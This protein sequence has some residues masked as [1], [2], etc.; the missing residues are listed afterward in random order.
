MSA[1][2]LLDL[3]DDALELVVRAI[4]RLDQDVV[5][6]ALVCTRLQIALRIVLAER[7][8]ALRKEL[9]LL[10]S[11][12][13]GKLRTHVEGIFLSEERIRY[14]RT[15]PNDHM[16][17][18][19]GLFKLRQRQGGCTLL[20]LTA[21]DLAVVRPSEVP[22]GVIWHMVRVAP[23]SVLMNCFVHDPAHGACHSHLAD[24][25][26]HGLGLLENRALLK[27]AAAHGRVDVL[28]ALY[29]W[30][31]HALRSILL[32]K[33][34]LRALLATTPPQ[35]SWKP[36]RQ[37][38]ETLVLPATRHCQKDVLAWINEKALLEMREELRAYMPE[39]RVLLFGVLRLKRGI[40]DWG[41]M[42]GVHHLEFEQQAASM[43]VLAAE[44]G[45]DE[46]FVQALDDI[47]KLWHSEGHLPES[48]WIG[49]ACNWL[50]GHLFGSRIGRGRLIRTVVAWCQEHTSTLR[51]MMN[52]REHQEVFDLMQLQHLNG[53]HDFLMSLDETEG[54]VD[55]YEWL[56]A[57]APEAGRDARTSWC[58]RARAQ[59]WEE[60]N[61][62]NLCDTI[63]GI[64]I[65]WQRRAK[66]QTVPAL[67][68]QR[69][70]RCAPED[71]VYASRLMEST[72]ALAPT[73]RQKGIAHVMERYMRELLSHRGMFGCFPHWVDGFHEASA[74]MLPVVERLIDEFGKKGCRGRSVLR[75]MLREAIEHA[76]TTYRGHRE[77]VLVALADLCYRRGLLTRSE[78]CQ[79]MEDAVREIRPGARGEQTVRAIGKQL[80]LLKA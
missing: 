34:A 52:A 58:A 9:H 68:E 38:M 77:D 45:F 28:E 56:L 11:P 29:P 40:L 61:V 79:V 57:D 23:C 59:M 1:T 65:H 51:V 37:L 27:F 14:V 80:G 16:R 6:V 55:Y 41:E 72:C 24:C 73:T 25:Y 4:D 32:S 53:Q 54:D 47:L 13:A 42:G 30:K 76:L 35:V 2:E 8:A 69:N 71:F 10:P 49:D 78:I 70:C 75:I 62:A 17:L 26:V 36:F 19:E 18:G 46:L 44:G 15:S 31:N 43:V 21:T 39:C 74:A 50:L 7:G 60:G 66:P 22:T 33:D 48:A 5:F 64:T 67:W 20:G 12:D 3:G 63:A